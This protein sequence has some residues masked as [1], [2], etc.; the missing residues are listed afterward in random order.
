MLTFR[1]LVGGKPPDALETDAMYLTSL[2]GQP[3]RAR[4]R[5]AAETGLLFCDR[6]SQGVAALNLPWTLK[7]GSRLMV[8]TALL[9]DREDP[10]LLPL[11]LARGQI[12]EAWRKKDDWGYIYREPGENFRSRFRDVRLLMARAVT[13]QDAP[14]AAAD[15]AEDALAQAVELGEDLAGADA[16]QGIARRRK[17]GQLARVDFGCYWDLAEENETVQVRF[18]RVFN[19][20][21]LPFAWRAI[22]PREQEFDWSWHDGWVQWLEAKGIGIKGGELVR[23]SEPYL[24]DWVW[25]W[26]NDFESIRDYVFDHCERCVQRF[27]GRVDHWDAVTGLHV[28]NC[29]G[30]SLD[31]ILEV[32]RVS[33]HAIKR[34][35]PS[36]R[37]VLNVVQPWGEYFATN[38][39]SIWPFHYAE[40]CMNAGIQFD[41]VGVQFLQGVPHEGLHCRD[42]LAASDMLDRFGSLGK[43]VH[44]TAVGA[45]SAGAPDPQ[46]RLDFGERDPGSGGVWH[47]RWD[48]AVQS[49]WLGAFYHVAIAKPFV[50]AVVWRDFSDHQTHHLA[51]GGLM[52][53]NLTPKIAFQRLVNVREK[54]WPGSGGGDAGDIFLAAADDE[55]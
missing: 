36:A 6:R 7:S 37:V 49:E 23:F 27:R 52:R 46:A 32:T 55:S 4:F 14:Q 38:Q 15:L 44:V 54:I 21:T 35:D 16:A 40:M 24:P 2:E 41:V 31:Q 51:H 50:R 25:I 17:G 8:R 10:Y 42:M 11:E 43:P 28:E 47:Q 18:S 5:Y 13:L 20:A 53:K 39:R 22:E 26:E 12:S 48:E 30:F 19:Y 34:T 45:P 1:V 9:P 33:V 3:I 29:M